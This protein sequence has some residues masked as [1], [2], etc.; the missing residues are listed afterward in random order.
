[1]RPYLPLFALLIACPGR[2][3][4]ADKFCER[5]WVARNAIFDRAG[6][7]FS[8]PLGKAVFDDADCRPGK[9]SLTAE[10]RAEVERLQ[11]AERQRGC[12]IDTQKRTLDIDDAPQIRALAVFG[13]PGSFEFSCIRFRG[14][15][16]LPLYSAPSG[17]A[18][19]VGRIKPGENVLFEYAERDGFELAAVGGGRTGEPVRLGWARIDVTR[20]CEDFAD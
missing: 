5:L 3:L 4:A 19:T 14:P 18:A 2:S 13:L 8:S 11:A 16:P 1:M 7:C 15:D 10:D 9:T 12:R 6:H 17:N 20:D